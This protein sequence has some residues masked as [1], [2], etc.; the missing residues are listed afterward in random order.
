M[1]LR[2]AVAGDAEA[3][4]ALRRAAILAGCASCYPADSLQRWTGG[5]ASPAF[6]EALA[7]LGHVA[8]Q[9]GV[10]V[11]SGMLDPTSGKIDA[12]F[13]DP[14]HMGQGLG[15]AMLA[16]LERLARA[17]GLERIH[18]DATLN[19]VAFYRTCGFAGNTRAWYRSPRGIALECVPM[20]KPLS[21]PVQP[22]TTSC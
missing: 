19:A 4:F 10:L 21:L 5:T 18:L 15:R 17:A 20:E 22:V 3:V 1:E 16:H 9:D 14:A 7:A 6:A 12:I 13:V 8:L 2:H 11:A